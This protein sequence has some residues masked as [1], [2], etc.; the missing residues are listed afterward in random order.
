MGSFIQGKKGQRAR[1]SK[2]RCDCGR[3]IAVVN[4]HL[5]TNHTQSC[6]CFHIDQISLSPGEAS[7]N[8]A[9][10]RIKRGAR[11]R[12]ISWDLDDA[13]VRRLVG[14]P[15]YW[16][17]V[18]RHNHHH[19]NFRFNVRLGWNGLDRLNNNLG[20]VTGNVVPCCGPCN[21]MKRTLTVDEF[22]ERCTRVANYAKSR[23][24]GS[25]SSDAMRTTKKVGHEESHQD[26][27]EHGARPSDLA[28]SPLRRR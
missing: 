28:S 8:L 22:I 14:E 20:Y 1:K 17:G 9:V 19:H 26:S 2:C 11:V 25:D 21:M 23:I 7:D 24:E 6:G 27:L 12:N 15:C 13:Y 5:T 4:S 3:E 16:C 18:V 10:D